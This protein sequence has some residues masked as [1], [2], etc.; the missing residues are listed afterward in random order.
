[1]Q[2]LAEQD[3]VKS[4]QWK[5]VVKMRIETLSTYS[6]HFGSHS[7]TGS[8]LTAEAIE[9]TPQIC[10]QRHKRYSLSTLASPHF[11]PSHQC[12]PLVEPNQKVVDEEA[13]EIQPA[14][15]SQPMVWRR[16]GEGGKR[17]LNQHR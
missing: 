14:V 13:W 11:L 3:K 7:R 15:V 2:H 17:G 1:M 5:E 9:E 8:I 10:H 4:G 12:L 6:L 16:T